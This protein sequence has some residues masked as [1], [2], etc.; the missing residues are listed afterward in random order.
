MG[1]LSHGGSGASERGC[2]NSLASERGCQSRSEP[3]SL[4]SERGDSAARSVGAAIFVV[5]LLIRL[6]PLGL[7]VTPDEPIWVLRSHQLLVAVE[8]GNWAAV[9]QTGHPGMTTMALGALGIWLTARLDP[10]GAAAHRDWIS[11]IASL[12]PENGAAFPHLV[13]FLPAGR[14]MVAL[15]TAGGLALAY[16]IGRRRLG[17]RAARLMALFLAVDPFF[18]GHSGLLHTDGLQATFVLLAVL[19]ACPEGNVF[20]RRDRHTC[21]SGPREPAHGAAGI[22]AAAFFLALA[23]LAKML[24]LLAAPGLALAVLIWWKD[25]IWRRGARVAALA[26]LTVGFLV[27]LYPPTWVQPRSALQSLISAVSYHEGIGLR[28]V[29][30]AGETSTDPGPWFYPV[31]LVFR[32][33]PPVLLG[34]LGFSW[35]R[36]GTTG[37]RSS[38]LLLTLLPAVS[39]LV[40]ISVA[41]KKFDRYVLSVIPLLTLVAAVAW[42]RRARAWRFGALASLALPWALVSVLP[43]QYA[44]PLLGGPWGAQAVVPLGWGEASGL[45]ARW[46]NRQHSLA[47]GA[48]VMT[49]NVPGIAGLF[50]G[51]TW[52]W[53]VANVGCTDFVIGQG[54][55]LPATYLLLADLWAAGRDQVRIYGHAPTVSIAESLVA[56]G[57]L[58]GIPADAAA[59]IADS[60][61]LATWLVQRLADGGAFTWVHAPQCYPLTEAQL[62]HIID[63]MA[64]RGALVCESW[65]P[66]LGLA[67]ER[68]TALSALPETAAFT[69]RFGGGLDLVEAAWESVVQAPR[70]LTVRLR[71]QAQVSLPEVE[72]YLA[73]RGAEGADGIVW[74]EGGRR[75]LSDWGW[76]APDWPVGKI[77]DAE[78]YI[79]LPLHLPPGT[80]SLVLRVS[81]PQGAMGLATPDGVFG[82]TEL[83]LG[84]VQVTP[85]SSAAGEIMLS[86]HIDGSWP[87]L[88][89]L[90]AD[91][92]VDGVLAGRRL[93]FSL[94]LERV[95]GTPPTTLL[96]D[97][98]C[99][100][101]SR[102]DGELPLEAAAL[103]RWPLG[104]RYVLRFAPRVGP[105]TPAG[106]C[107]LSVG[108]RRSEA[109]GDS[110]LPLAVGEHVVLGAVAVDQRPRRYGAPEALDVVL[111]V[112]ADQ[113]ADL[114]GIDVSA[115]ELKPGDR[116]SVTLYWRAR[117]DAARDYT[118]FVHAVGP[119]DQVWAQSDAWPAQGAAPTMTWTPG[120]IIADEHSLVLRDGAPSGVYTLY[121]G[122]YDAGNGS[123]VVLSVEG[124]RVQDDRVAVTVFE[125]GHEP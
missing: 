124:E 116:L 123:R 55:G 11:R 49:G 110:A 81:G 69:A 52:P 104:Y 119:D 27:V 108:P 118:V 84:K 114:L 42:L 90:G 33:T 21:A 5:A 29:F 9:P 17:D 14:V 44:N 12:A 13:A 63:A 41:G 98:E 113:W 36:R 95:A 78:A 10:V 111:H 35:F 89:V 91:L 62:R 56:P 66:V 75:L 58:P 67:T 86:T 92:S 99:G 6:M 74:S 22:V 83:I 115:A 53:V 38:R 7:Y 72:V 4:A 96:W 60:D 122:L 24:G 76:A 30:F 32:L 80:Y 106:E 94:G 57:L 37:G 54:T 8:T 51:E 64:A 97:L 121:V 34:L 107:T 31:V 125:V 85:A 79:P 105:H 26:M 2:Q 101:V 16:T 43:L 117:G 102:A 59:P 19:F 1:R 82:G 100:G 71:W 40:G 65:N 77:A 45:A 18:A 88:K 93:P 23:G 48:S 87:G 28:P 73:L 3:D 61:T 70:P 25:S 47:E 112:S 103:D 50:A 39:Y 120:E 68:C 20:P 15:V 109:G 46:L